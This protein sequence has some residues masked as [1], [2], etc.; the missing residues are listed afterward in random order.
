M[1]YLL[2][3]VPPYG[4]MLEAQHQPRKFNTYQPL[5]E[6]CIQRLRC[7]LERYK[8][9]NRSHLVAVC[10]SKR[11]RHERGWY[12]ERVREHTRTPQPSEKRGRRRRGDFCL[13]WDLT[14]LSSSWWLEAQTCLDWLQTWWA[15]SLLWVL[16]S[17]YTVWNLGQWRFRFESSFVSSECCSFST[18]Q[19]WETNTLGRQTVSDWADFWSVCWELICVLVYQILCCLDMRFKSS[20]LI[21][22]GD[23]LWYLCFIVSYLL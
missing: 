21:A 20:S 11:A 14:G 18:D 3:Y 10:E 8:G 13:F 5:I 22:E 23:R 12:C 7:L 1:L 19:F 17:G 2:G 9:E 16:R 6:V 15:C 4:G